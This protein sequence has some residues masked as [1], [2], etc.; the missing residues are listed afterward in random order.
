MLQNFFV[1]WIFKTVGGRLWRY[2]QGLMRSFWRYHN[3]RREYNC[4]KEAISWPKPDRA[5]LSWTQHSWVLLSGSAKTSLAK[6]LLTPV[7]LLKKNIFHFGPKVD[8]CAKFLLLIFLFIRC[9]QLSGADDS[10]YEK[11]IYWN[12]IVHTKV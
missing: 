5:R 7:L 3:D 8:M 9:W 1:F 12:F 6:Y 2:S 4:L 11:K 10:G